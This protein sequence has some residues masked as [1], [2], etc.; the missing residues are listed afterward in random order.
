MRGHHSVTI[1]DNVLEEIV[2]LSVRY[3]KDRFLPDKAIDLMDESAS[4]LGLLSVNNSLSERGTSVSSL[5]ERVREAIASGNYAEA[6]RLYSM[7]E[8]PKEKES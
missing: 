8:S 1:P 4:K 5:D 3:V 6:R 7:K 2:R